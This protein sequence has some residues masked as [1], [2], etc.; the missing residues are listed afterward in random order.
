MEPVAHRLEVVLEARPGEPRVA[1]ARQVGDA[2]FAVAEH[3]LD[4]AGRHGELAA[5]RAHPD[6][7][8]DV[9]RAEVDVDPD[10][11]ARVVADRGVDVHGGI[12]VALLVEIRLDALALVADRALAANRFPR[13][14]RAGAHAQP[15]A[16]VFV[17]QLVEQT[18]EPAL[19]VDARAHAAD[20]RQRLEVEHEP[21]AA[22][23]RADR[24]ADELVA[25]L[26]G[27]RGDVSPRHRGEVRAV[28]VHRRFEQ[29]VQRLGRV[30]ADVRAG[31]REVVPRDR[32]GELVL[33]RG[34]F[35]Q[36]AG[37]G[38]EQQA[39]R[40]VCPRRGQRAIVRDR[41]GWRSR[42]GV[43]GARQDEQEHEAG[44]GLQGGPFTE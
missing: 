12:G 27:E 10:L 25:E 15:A 37:R 44:E 13:Q 34:A 38:V 40:A 7:A 36:R 4:R 28:L 29:R 43:H 30:T 22:G 2:V 20:Q 5:R 32:G 9:L 3:A 1:R 6:L 11:D 18:E 33:G 23:L 39:G 31:H 26:G 21:V 8:D 14:V 19:A 16:D 35:E 42:L 17:E 24:V 41:G